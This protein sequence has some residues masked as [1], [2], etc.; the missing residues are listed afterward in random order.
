MSHKYD[1]YDQNICDMQSPAILVIKS[2][3]MRWAG[4]VARMG[5]RRSIYGVLLGKPEGQGSPERPRW[6]RVCN[7]KVDLK[8]VGCGGVDWIELAQDRDR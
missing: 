3:G 1:S 5:E 6:K 8:E 4:C 7:V 2:R